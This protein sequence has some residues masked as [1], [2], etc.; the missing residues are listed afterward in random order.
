MEKL[1]RSKP[2]FRAYLVGAYLFS[3]PV[4]AYSESLGL[5]IIPQI[6]GILLTSY[7]ILDILR[8]IKI[9]IPLEIQLYGLLGLWAASTFIFAISKDEMQIKAL[10]TLIKVVIATLA[11]TQLIKDETDLLK[12]LKIFILSSFVVYYLNRHELLLLR[13]SDGIIGAK[14]LAST[15]TNPNFAANY[16][17]TII[18]ASVFIFLYNRKRLLEL[19]FF[20][21]PIGISLLIIYHA[22]SKKGLI[23]IGLL[24]LFLGR[25]LYIRAKSSSR[26]TLAILIS[27]F[28]VALVV[29]FIFTSPFF[30]RLNQFGRSKED[31]ERLDLAGEAIN[32]WL[33]NFKTFIMGVGYDNFRLISIY[34]TYAHST[35]FELLASSGIIGC[36]LFG[37]FLFLLFRKFAFLYRHAPTAKSK[38]TYFSILVLFYL[39]FLFMLAEPLQDSRELLPILGIIAAF[40]QHNILK[41]KQC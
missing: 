9:K 6:M 30:Y 10:G 34:H 35:P 12:A 40:G 32:V 31:I 33:M 14:R 8:N 27:I 2:S 38:S 41:L 20:I 19:I 7:A 11:C 3:V 37:A 16:A 17:L 21:M 23:G 4:F 25:L 13:F 22:G 5:L 39:F 1:D 29:Y 24:V 26:K 18:W 15:I 28:L 36:S